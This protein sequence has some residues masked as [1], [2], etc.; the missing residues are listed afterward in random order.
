MTLIKGIP[1]V[2][3]LDFSKMSDEQLMKITINIDLTSTEE[4]NVF[5]EEL[6][7]RNLEYNKNQASNKKLGVSSL[8][9]E[10]KI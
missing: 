5:L 1:D 10:W 7:K 3:M 6:K 9:W 4:T 8:P 2:E